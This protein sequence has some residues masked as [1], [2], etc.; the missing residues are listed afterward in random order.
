[1][2]IKD[3]ECLAGGRRLG[4]AANCPKCRVQ[5]LDAFRT[6]PRLDY[7]P[8]SVG[9]PNGCPFCNV[10]SNPDL[11]DHVR[12]CH[13]DQFELW[14]GVVRLPAPP[15]PPPGHGGLPH[16]FMNEGRTIPMDGQPVYPRTG[17]CPYCVGS[18]EYTDLPAHMQRMHPTHYEEW[19]QIGAP[20]AGEP[21]HPPVTHQ[22]S[23][24][25]QMSDLNDDGIWAAFCTCGWKVH[26][27]FEPGTGA[28]MGLL[29]AVSRAVAVAQQHKDDPARQHFEGECAP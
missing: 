11:R 20:A 7:V 3:H 24:G 26:G 25:A 13:P 18:R 17:R 9:G 6:E 29:R 21:Y 10:S 4:E 12:N 16:L 1:M 22:T 8:K 14:A 28:A 5:L 15:G 23:S 27:H 2:T 19:L